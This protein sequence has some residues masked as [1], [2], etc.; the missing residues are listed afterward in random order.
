M[1]KKYSQINLEE[2]ELLSSLHQSGKTIR[3]ISAIMDRS[4]STISREL[5]RNA[6]PKNE[7]QAYYAHQVSQSKRWTGTKL[8]RDQDLRNKVLSALRRGL[9]PE[10]VAGRYKL[11]KGHNIISH[12]TIYRFIYSQIARHKDY[13]WRHYLPQ[14]RSKRRLRYKGKYRGK[15][16]KNWVSIHE[17]GPEAETRSNIKHWESDLMHFRKQSAVLHISTERSSLFMLASRQES[18]KS[19]PLIRALVRKMKDIPKSKRASITFDNG[20]EFSEHEQLHSLDMK[21]YFCDIR[22]PW[23]KGGV[24]NSIGRLRRYLPRKTNLKEISCYQL[25]K[26]IEN[27]NQTPRKCLGYLTPSEVFN[28]EVLHFKRESTS[29]YLQG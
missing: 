8:D 11:E 19:R 18:K 24:E 28:S 20:T 12:E 5:R 15:G 29:L 7:Y 16:I 3:E 17:R 21:T 1:G 9:S 23:Q 6:S 4:P 27:Y 10:Q 26:I 22:A 25:N 14:A 13:T 2:R